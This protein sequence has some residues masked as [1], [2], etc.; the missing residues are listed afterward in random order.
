MQQLFNIL[1]ILHI[2]GG[3]I[4]LISGTIAAAVVKGRKAHTTNG[5]I[6]FFAM[7]TAAVS[8]LIISN[9][10]SHINVFLF[11]VGGFTFYMICS[12][13]RAVWLKRNFGKTMK[14][15]SLIDYSLTL[16]AVAFGIFLI[17]LSVKSVIQTDMFGIVP[18][19]FGVICL[20]YAA[21]DYRYLSGKVAVKL[22]WM[23]NHITRMMGAMIASYTAFLV[24]NV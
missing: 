3:T 11:A 14:S 1:L 2:A 4:G 15:F 10:P 8:S 9:M 6:F 20:S 5:K 19:I 18:G 23:S 22:S 21:L 7:L 13:Y 12:G 24:V 17:T 16:F